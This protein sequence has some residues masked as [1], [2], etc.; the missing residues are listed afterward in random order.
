MNVAVYPV[1]KVY[2]GKVL[3]SVKSLMC[4]S[5]IDKIVLTIE[6]D[7]YPGYLPECVE[8]INARNYVSDFFSPDGPNIRRTPYVYLCML[9]VAYPMMFTESRILSLDADV[10][11]V[12]DIGSELWDMDLHGHHFAGVPEELISSQIGRPYANA[13]VFLL[14]CDAIHKD[15]LD[16]RMIEL[17][18][19]QDFQWL[20]QDCFNYN[21]ELM[22][23]SS[24]YNMCQFTEQVAKPK[25]LHY[26]YTFDWEAKGPVAAYRNTSWEEV[27]EIWKRRKQRK[28]VVK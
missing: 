20:E 14:D 21:C 9:R 16:S 6:D 24:E 1:S 8:T 10:I 2:Y 28:K 17:M 22:P 5:D 18:N 4:N 15:G 12:R 26:A 19:R 7:K 25:I 13:G 3:P 11:V 23:I 27:E